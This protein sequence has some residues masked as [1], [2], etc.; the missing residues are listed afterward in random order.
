MRAVLLPVAPDR[1][2]QRSHRFQHAGV[3]REHHALHRRETMIPGGIHEALY[4]ERTVALVR[5]PVADDDR[6]FARLAVG[7]DHV[8]G[9]TR[10]PFRSPLA[11]IMATLRG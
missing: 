9:D 3:V 4:R 8:A 11:P 7:I 10:P 2:S 5:H 1:I 6:E